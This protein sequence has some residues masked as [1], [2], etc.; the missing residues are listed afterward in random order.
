MNPLQ[1]QQVGFPQFVRGTLD[2]ERPGIHSR[3]R[4]G[5]EGFFFTIHFLRDLSVLGG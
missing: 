1:L 2:D 3:E 5:N 4:R